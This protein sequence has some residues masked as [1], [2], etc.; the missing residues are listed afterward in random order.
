MLSARERG[1]G[2]CGGAVS[3]SPSAR[4]WGESHKLPQWVP[5]AEN[6]EFCAFWDLKIASKGQNSVG[7]M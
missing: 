6:F 1:R 2:S 7:L 4:E 3:P 5:G